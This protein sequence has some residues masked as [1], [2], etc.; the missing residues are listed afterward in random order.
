MGTVAPDLYDSL[1]SSDL[2]V[3]KGDLN[4]RKLAHDCR[5]A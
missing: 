1:K 3:F 2:L 5:F 4:Y